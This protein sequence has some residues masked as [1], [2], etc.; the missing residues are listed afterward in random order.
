MSRRTCEAIR[1]SSSGDCINNKYARKPTHKTYYAQSNPQHL[2]HE[3]ANE[4][5]KREI[6]ILDV[7]A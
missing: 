4:I 7:D 2:I 3:V 1:L 5:K 6:S